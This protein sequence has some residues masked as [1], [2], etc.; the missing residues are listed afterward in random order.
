M[1]ET[2]ITEFL[3]IALDFVIIYITRKNQELLVA[4]KAITKKVYVALD[5]ERIK[6]AMRT[7]DPSDDMISGELR[8][9]HDYNQDQQQK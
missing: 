4:N 7:P 8:L 6:Q 2:K 9:P 5:P 3:I 1:L